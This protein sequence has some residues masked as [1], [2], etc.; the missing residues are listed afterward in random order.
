LPTSDTVYDVSAS[1]FAEASEP[2][3]SRRRVWVAALGVWAVV[4]CFYR[5]GE[6]P[7][8]IANE[9]REGVY[10][11]AMLASGDFIA[12]SVANHVENGET[13]PD[14]PPLFH[15]LAAAATWSRAALVG[16]RL[17]AGTE[18]AA[19]F[20]EWALRFPS[21][22][23]AVTLIVATALLGRAFVGERAALF[24][25]AVLL[26]MTQFW[27][28]SRFGR[29]DMLLACCATLATLFAGRA[30]L[31]GRASLL[32]IAG[33]CAGFAVLAKG[34]LG[35][36]LPALAYAS[37]VALQRLRGRPAPALPWRSV[38]LVMGSVA[39]PWYAASHLATGGATLRSQIF[40]ETLTQF[41]GPDG[42]MPELFYL[43]PWI[44]D[45]LPWNLVA[46]ASLFVVWKR[47]DPGA[48]FCAVWWLS[49][50]L[51][52]QIA[53]YKRRAY[54]L[55]ALPAEALLA[56]WLL[57]RWVASGR[58]RSVASTPSLAASA[59]AIGA[60]ALAGPLAV[61]RWASLPVVGSAGLLLAAI[62][63]GTM[64]WAL[65]AFGAALAAGDRRRILVAVWLF[66]GALH[67]AVSP[68]ILEATAE[69][70]TARNL[71][72]R[73]ELTVPAGASFS[74]CGID[75]DPTLPLLFYARDPQKI[76]IG[77]GPSC[78]ESAQTGF[79]LMAERDRV[80][81]STAKRCV[82]WREIFHDE[83]RGWK[84][85]IPVTFG[86][87]LEG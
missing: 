76:V 62:G 85:T 68:L 61:A 2:V 48:T 50:L 64:A 13:V 46:A 56:G 60:G 84:K 52:F 3:L 80:R 53:A 18:L 29:V 33:V 55:P 63:G 73:I 59:F 41:F 30:I 71:V 49:V 72:R 14:K 79:Y 36:L 75:P 58:A 15:W 16:R 65:C 9:A 21:A 66:L 22:L 11:R 67:L 42:R 26:T 83:I 38:L 43:R 87:C 74:V 35:A 82:R 31:E 57:D 28:Q 7:V 39:L 44:L 81:A 17:P 12:P 27:Y 51:F 25:G 40:A 1:S 20:D 10:A 47:R 86:E 70:L 5:L 34:P 6:A 37:F 4:A 78:L 19:Q 54:L 8:V 24:A 32:A 45:S 23:A 69:P 77:E